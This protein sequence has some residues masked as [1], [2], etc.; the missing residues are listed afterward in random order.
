MPKYII[1]ERTK[2]LLKMLCLSFIAAFIGTTWVGTTAAL[3]GAPGSSLPVYGM[4][5]A[6]L[7]GAISYMITIWPKVGRLA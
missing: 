6:I 2:A 4:I 1:S 3:M 7:G 5:G